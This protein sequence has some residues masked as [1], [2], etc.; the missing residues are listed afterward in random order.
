[1]PRKIWN[2]D[3]CARIDDKLMLASTPLDGVS[4]EVVKPTLGSCVH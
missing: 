4:E 2:G 1:M 3:A